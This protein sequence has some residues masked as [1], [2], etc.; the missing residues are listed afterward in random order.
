M[1]LD[2]ISY[3]V[4]DHKIVAVATNNK[5]EQTGT[6]WI[7]MSKILKATLEYFHSFLT[8]KSQ[9]TKIKHLVENLRPPNDFKGIDANSSMYEFG[10][11]IVYYKT[12]FA[13]DGSVLIAGTPEKAPPSRKSSSRVFPR[14]IFARNTA[15]PVA[16]K[17]PQPR[18]SKKSS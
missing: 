13:H 8:G 12:P 7:H 10:F 3:P 16:E 14:T 15:P 11:F 9:W 2:G 6:T 5:G 4:L 17:K 18:F 1:T